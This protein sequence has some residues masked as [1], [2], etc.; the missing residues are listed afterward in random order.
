MTA[1]EMNT[2]Y[3]G[4]CS[5][6]VAVAGLG[7][8][9]ALTACDDSPSGSLDASAG[10]DAGPVDDAGA[11]GDSAIADAG[12]PGSGDAGAG[13]GGP[14]ARY[15]LG[16]DT[17]EDREQGITWQRAPGSAPVTFAGAETY[18]AELELAGGGW[19]QPTFEELESI[20][21]RERRPTID[22][23]VF[24][25]TPPDWYWSSTP[26]DRKSVV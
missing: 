1:Y 16:E 9:L 2:R 8:V 3:G 11:A 7:F 19:R 25:G 20:V 22:T 12:D 4:L 5:R 6:I 24:P 21:I 18:C 13:D 15:V 23:E 26:E 10:D 14:I 17:V